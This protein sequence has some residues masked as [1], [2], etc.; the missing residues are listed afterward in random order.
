MPGQDPERGGRLTDSSAGHPEWRGPMVLGLLEQL[1]TAHYGRATAKD[2]TC[3]S[4]QGPKSKQST[5]R[6]GNGEK[7]GSLEHQSFDTYP[8]SHPNLDL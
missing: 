4:L 3:R 1:S 8:D 2:L 5:V 6:S 7:G